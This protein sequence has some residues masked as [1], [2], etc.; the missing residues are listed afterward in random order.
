M[1]WE[2]I[3]GLKEKAWYTYVHVCLC[4]FTVVKSQKRENCRLEQLGP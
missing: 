2:L 3:G 1:I 4:T